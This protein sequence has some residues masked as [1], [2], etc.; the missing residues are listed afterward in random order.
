MKITKRKVTAIVVALLIASSVSAILLY[1]HFTPPAIAQISAKLRI[2]K[3]EV[4]VRQ[5]ERIGWLRARNGAALGVGDSVRTLTSGLVTVTYFEKSI[6]R[7]S[8]NSEISLKET[9]RLKDSTRATRITLKQVLGKSWQRVEK[10]A[11]NESRFEVETPAA[12]ASVRGTVFRVD[13]ERSGKSV[14]YVFNGVVEIKAGGKRVS[15]TS[16][17]KIIVVPGAAVSLDLVKKMTSRDKDS[18]YRWNMEAD[19]DLF[20]R[21]KGVARAPAAESQRTPAAGSAAQAP[22]TSVARTTPSTTTSPGTISNVSPGP[23]TSPSPTVPSPGTSPQPPYLPFPPVPPT[24]PGYPAPPPPLVP[25]YTPPP[26][27]VPP[28]PTPPSPSPP[29]PGV[30]DTLPPIIIVLKPPEIAILHQPLTIQAIIVDDQR[31]ASAQ[32]V[33]RQT[34]KSKWNILQMTDSDGDSIYQATIPASAAKKPKIEYYLVA[35]DAAGNTSVD[36]ADAPNDAYEVE[37]EPFH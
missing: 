35:R 13:V 7:L 6:T 37:V 25:P 14:F 33:Y 12:V 22:G 34:K 3:G 15:L 27:G 18:W 17:E 20:G 24:P 11:R 30:V 10:Q 26:P 5:N 1:S 19:Q 23:T 36:P 21:K 28:P 8:P 29:P 32:L 2:V 4:R 16:G 31:V 9:G